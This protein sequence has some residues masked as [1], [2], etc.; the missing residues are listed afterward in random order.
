MDTNAKSPDNPLQKSK[1][2]TKSHTVVL[3]GTTYHKKKTNV[4]V[5]P[6]NARLL[7][8]VDPVVPI[9]VIINR[10]N[11]NTVSIIFN[12]MYAFVLAHRLSRS[13]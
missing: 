10:A 2:S 1:V 4:A 13:M 6:P 12:I 3:I 8:L 7:P 9:I 5:I 11:Q